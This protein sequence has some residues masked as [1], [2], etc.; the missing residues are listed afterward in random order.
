MLRIV[1]LFVV[2]KAIALF[3]SPVFSLTWTGVIEGDFNVHALIVIAGGIFILYTALKEIMHMLAI[4]ELG[5]ESTEEKKSVASAVTWIVIMNLVFSF[6][7]ILSAIAHRRLGHGC[8]HHSIGH[9]DDLPADMCRISQEEPDVRGSWTL[10]PLYRWG[11]AFVRGRASG[12]ET[13]G[14]PVEAMA[15]LH[16][17]GAMVPLSLISSRVGTRRSWTQN[18]RQK[19]SNTP[20]S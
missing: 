12:P 16:F 8:C 1:L 15:S 18:R 5:E 9:H 3:Q 4:H 17:I 10:H 14:H 11:D 20:D 2:V 13:R 19:A 6:D 7:S